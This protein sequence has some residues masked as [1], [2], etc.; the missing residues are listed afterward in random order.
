MNI[1]YK[2]QANYPSSE[3][4]KGQGY[5]HKSEIYCVF[6][7]RKKN[8]LAAIVAEIY[9]KVLGQPILRITTHE[10]FEPF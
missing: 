5:L 10:P 8:T 6:Q 3:G 7:Y 2:M 1:T 9:A 4:Q